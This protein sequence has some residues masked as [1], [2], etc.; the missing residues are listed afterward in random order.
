MTNNFS[1]IINY[2]KKIRRELHKKP[3]LGWDE[4]NTSKKIRFILDK[5]N[6]KWKELS[7]TGTVAYLA[8]QK[9]GKHIA[10]RCDIDA[11]SISEETGL[12]YA[13]E[14]KNC[15]HACGHDGHTATLIAVAI[16]LKQ[17]ELKL[18]GPVSLIFQ[19]A[20]EG[21][22]G[23]RSLIAAG[24][25]DGVEAIYGW[26]NW[27][28]IKFGEAL[29]PDGI[30]M[31]GNGTFHI[32][33]IGKGGHSSQ[34]EMCKDP[35]LAAAA[36]TMSLQ[37]IVSRNMS[38]LK[39]SVVSVTSI[40]APSGVT[41]IPNIAKLHGSI[42]VSD[43]E[44]KIEIQK[45]IQSITF[46]VAKGYGVESVIEFRDRYAPTV[47]NSNESNNVRKV[48]TEVL[49][50]N[51]KSNH[52]SPLMASEDFSYYLDVIPGAYTLIGSNEGDLSKSIPCHNSKYDFNDKLIE[53]ASKILIR[54]ANYKGDI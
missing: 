21:G 14:N 50:D 53:P 49:G 38:P 33:L 28:T 42:R 12:E 20:E 32:K 41:S 17:N 24:C 13:S 36:V 25:L 39:I 35:V 8:E 23:A 9:K 37:Q 34:P 47:N 2:A 44:M 10:L 27:P 15:M 43:K 30:I 22:H 11:L 3:E 29:C 48:L 18:P 6:I 40:D 16:F 45:L 1:N 31:A 19:P 52:L 7:Q 46:N 5:Y 4:Y 26:H 54:L 51:W